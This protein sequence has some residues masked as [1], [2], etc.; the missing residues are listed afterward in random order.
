MV[1]QPVDSGHRGHW[2]L[3]DLVALGEDQV[4]GDDDG[5]LLVALARKWKRTSISSG[6]C[7]T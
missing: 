1:N 2:V 6:D 3:E 7:W 4:G 5:L